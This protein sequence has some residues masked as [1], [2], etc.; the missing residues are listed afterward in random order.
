MGSGS[1]AIEQTKP[2]N[3]NNNNNG[4]GNTGYTLPPISV[5]GGGGGGGLVASA[6]VPQFTNESKYQP[7][8]RYDFDPPP[9][10]N[11]Q[12]QQQQQQQATAMI[13][14]KL[15]RLDQQLSDQEES[16]RSMEKWLEQVSVLARRDDQLLRNDVE[17]QL[18]AQLANLK[19]HFLGVVLKQNESN[20]QAISDAHRLAVEQLQQHISE[21]A[22]RISGLEALVRQHQEEQE[23]VQRRAADDL[24][25]VKGE[26]QRALENGLTSGTRLI[27]TELLGDLGQQLSRQ[28][29]TELTS[30]QRAWQNSLPDQQ[31]L[32]TRLVSKCQDQLVQ[33]LVPRLTSDLTGT[34]MSGQA[35]PAMLDQKLQPQLAQ[36]Q[37]GLQ[38][39][40]RRQEDQ[41][42]ELIQAL[43]TLQQLIDSLRRDN[44]RKQD[45]TAAALADLK[46]EMTSTCATMVHDLRREMYKTVSA[47]VMDNNNNNYNSNNNNNSVPSS[48]L[49]ST[50]NGI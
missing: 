4:E 21:Q 17:T 18:S 36:F 11:N 45:F 44:S 14:D 6:P 28:C 24:A 32:V 15:S 46:K 40:R 16:M 37:S 29:Q 39:L 5:G 41:S 50:R 42:Q 3:Y 43:A 9:V 1:S 26:M 8:S 7:S 10:N 13:E 48:S 12:L 2:R 23:R 20:V 19:D 31:D 27:R 22:S 33:T 34:I 49:P 38:D 25:Q 35:L 30:A 47:S